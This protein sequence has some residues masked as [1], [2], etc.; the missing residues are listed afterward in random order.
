MYLEIYEKYTRQRLDIIKVFDFVQYTKKFCGIGTFKIKMSFQ[1]K[2]FRYVKEGNYILFD[3]DAIGI[4]KNIS[5]DES[6]YSSVEVNGFLVNIILSYRVIK[7]TKNFS[8]YHSEVVK[9]IVDGEFITTTSSRV[10]DF[11]DISNDSY[12][13][14]SIKFQNT[15]GTVN[16]LIEQILQSISFGYDLIPTF[17]AYD[18]SQDIPTNIDK[19]TFKVLKP[20]Y[21]TI[22]N[23]ENNDPVIFSFDLFNLQSLN[24]SEDSS[25]FCSYAYVAGEGE[26]SERKHVDVYQNSAVTGIDLIELFVDARDLQ[27]TIGEQTMTQQEYEAVLMQRGK[28]KLLEHIKNQFFDAKVD[29][30]EH[31]IF[32]LN[33]D[34]FLGDFVTLQDNRL[35]IQVDLQITEITKSLTSEGEKIDVM[36][37]TDKMTIYE[38][39]KKEVR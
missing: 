16:E 35:N 28:E 25:D 11:L 7:T 15:G 31:S 39:I 17:T 22:G 23:S 2:S 6:D 32:K 29:V 33:E 21:R 36:F 4:I 26:G 37:G 18:E 14:Q 27:S 19:F 10:I 3:D 5:I 34:Y 13:T 1:D 30:S 8:G 20:S 9:D 12:T 38:M 24:Y